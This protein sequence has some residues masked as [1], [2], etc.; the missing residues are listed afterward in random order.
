VR[1]VAHLVALTEPDDGRKVVL[2]DA[3]V[4]AVV[5]DVGRQEQRVAATEDALLAQVG[6]EPIHFIHELVGL[7]DLG[8]FSEPFTDLGEEGDVAV[9]DGTVVL[10]SG[11]GELLDAARGRT[12]HELAGPRVI[13]LLCA[14]R[15]RREQERDTTGEGQHGERARHVES[16]PALTFRTST[17]ALHTTP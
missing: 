8:W 3:E 10:E 7:H 6:R 5:R 14:E 12:L 13:P 17:T 9:R 1:H 11:V 2:D 15:L 4:V 16:S